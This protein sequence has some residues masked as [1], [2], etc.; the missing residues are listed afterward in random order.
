MDSVIR[1]MQIKKITGRTSYRIKNNG[2]NVGTALTSYGYAGHLDD[3]FTPTNDINFGAP[4]EIY[5]SATTYP[6]TNLF[7]AYYSD[8]IAEITSEYSK[9]LSC[10]VLLNSFD[11]QNLDF[12]KF[13]YIDNV[14]YRLNIVDSY[15][16]INY[17]T[18]KVEL[19]KVID[20]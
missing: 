10:N 18:T 4:Q 19:L 8:Y 13:V 12:S 15:N 17:T 7:A 3:P 9:L 6:A 11:I 20:K 16:P 1:I 5:L 2:T 14:L